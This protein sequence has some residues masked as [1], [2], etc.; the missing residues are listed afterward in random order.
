MNKSLMVAMA[1]LCAF[2]SGC[3][4]LTGEGTGQ[5]LSIM[6]YTTDNKDLTGAQCELKND[7]GT[8]TAVTPATV[9][10]R[11]SNKDLMVKCT[12]SGLSDA[13]ANVVS[14]TKGNMFGNI[15]FGGGI[16]AIID[17]NNGSAYEYPSVLK[18]I[19]G[20]DSNIKEGSQ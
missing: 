12:K 8:W 11:R 15:I 2:A 13:R 14:K 7:E 18:L 3:S 9:M 1:A 17:H 5:N 20:Q 19:M 6:T 4:T 10:V 16:G